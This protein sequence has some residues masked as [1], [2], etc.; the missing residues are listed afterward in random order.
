[1][2][3]RG[4]GYPFSWHLRTRASEE[5]SDFWH[6]LLRHTAG[7]PPP[8]PA[9][10]LASAIFVTNTAS[11]AAISVAAFFLAARARPCLRPF[12]ASL[13]ARWACWR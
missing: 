7:G 6:N 10:A 4:S 8:R 11:Y 5:A 9:A 3:R 2:S 1:M 13:E 12:L